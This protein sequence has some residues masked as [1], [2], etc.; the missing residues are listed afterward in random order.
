MQFTPEPSPSHSDAAGQAIRHCCGALREDAPLTGTSAAA[1]DQPPGGAGHGAGLMGSRY[2]SCDRISGR[3]RRQTGDCHHRRY[4]REGPERRH[5]AM[6]PEQQVPQR[7][8]CPRAKAASCMAA[9]GAAGENPSRPTPTSTAITG[10]CRCGTCRHARRD[11]KR[12]ARLS[13]SG[14][15][16]MTSNIS[17]TTAAH[18]AKTSKA[19]RAFLIGGGLVGGALRQSASRSHPNASPTRGLQTAGAGGEVAFNA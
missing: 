10:L 1:G 11:R 17:T 4:W 18:R 6:D 12:A 3:C 19:R 2:V 8:Y 15:V 13:E 14:G 16:I 7:G 5:A 9:H